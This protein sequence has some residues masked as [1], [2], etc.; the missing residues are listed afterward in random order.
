LLAGENQTERKYDRN[1]SRILNKCRWEK[2][3]PF[4]HVVAV[5]VDVV[6]VDVAHHLQVISTFRH[7]SILLLVWHD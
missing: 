6:V 7:I 4:P 1:C 2:Y 3:L 5:V